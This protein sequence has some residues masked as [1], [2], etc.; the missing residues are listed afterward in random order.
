MTKFILT[1]SFDFTVSGEPVRVSN[2]T[3]IGGEC[4]PDGE[5]ERGSIGFVEAK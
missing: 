4:D 3:A 1:S 5:D 2:T